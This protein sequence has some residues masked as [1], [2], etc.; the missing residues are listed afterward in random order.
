MT[1]G[2][3]VYTLI[4]VSKVDKYS[5]TGKYTSKLYGPGINKCLKKRLISQALQGIFESIVHNVV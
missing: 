4:N 2:K 3:R 1:V 5:K